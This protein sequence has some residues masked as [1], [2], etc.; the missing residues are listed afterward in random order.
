[1]YRNRFCAST[2]GSIEYLYAKSSPCRESLPKNMI[3]LCNCKTESRKTQK[4]F[5]LI[6]KILYL[7][8]A[9]LYLFLSLW[10]PFRVTDSFFCHPGN[11]A[12]S[13]C[14]RIPLLCYESILLAKLV[15]GNL[16]RAQR[17]MTVL[18]LLFLKIHQ[19]K[20][21]FF[22]CYPLITVTVTGKLIFYQSLIKIIITINNI[23]EFYIKSIQQTLPLC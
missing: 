10:P 20:I 7:N 18:H 5:N 6:N 8:K 2:D 4:C 11:M 17:Y 19:S 3:T 14:Y 1:M 23:I 12:P 9:Y 15:W 22:C 21:L 16:S 13:I